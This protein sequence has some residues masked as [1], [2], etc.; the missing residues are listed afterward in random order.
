MKIA[1]IV[2][3]VVESQ[4]YET[5]VGLARAAL[6]RGHEVLFANVGDCTLRVDGQVGLHAARLK[7]PF[8]D[9]VKLVEALRQ[10][11][12]D[13]RI[14]AQEL[15]VLFLRNNPSDDLENRPWAQTSDILFGQCARHSGTLVLNDPDTL[16]HAYVDKMY[17]EQFP[18]KVRPR[19][20]ITRNLSEIKRFYKDEGCQMVLKP[21]QGSGGEDVF[22]VDKKEP[23]LKQM[24]E[25]ISRKGY[26]VAQQFLPEAKDGD[27]RLFMINGR[28]FQHKGKYCAFRRVNRSDFRSNMHQGGKALKARMTDEILD[29]AKLLGPKLVQDGIFC[30]GLD[31]VG[32]K[33]V[34]I[35]ITSPGGMAAAARLEKVDFEGATIEA[36]ERKLEY[37]KQ[38]GDRIPNRELAVVE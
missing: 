6:D 17:F 38:Y 37:R 7:D 12:S 1:F 8:E 4:P 27:I 25:A 15:D 36:I 10:E 26:V 35:N 21:L 29:I 9:K 3:S 33:L 14:S 18:K 32:N 5:T 22:F 31:F 11:N 16:A 20:V 19:A 23:N 34:E 28:P 30:A 24:V 2:N 13:T